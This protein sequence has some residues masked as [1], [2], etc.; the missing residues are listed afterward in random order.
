MGQDSNSRSINEH[1]KHTFIVEN[2]LEG[3]D[4]L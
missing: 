3:K 4:V 1:L 2:K